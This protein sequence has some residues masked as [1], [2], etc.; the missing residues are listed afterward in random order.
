MVQ[1]SFTGLQEGA[2]RFQP[3]SGFTAGALR[4]VGRAPGA[5]TGLPPAACLWSRCGRAPPQVARFPPAIGIPF[6]KY[7]FFDRPTESALD[8]RF[9]PPAGV[10]FGKNGRF[11]SKRRQRRENKG[12]SM[13]QLPP[14]RQRSPWMTTRSSDFVGDSWLGLALLPIF[15]IFRRRRKPRTNK[16][17][18][19]GHWPRI[20]NQELPLLLGRVAAICLHA[21]PTN[22][23]L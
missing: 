7:A 3:Q 1:A 18:F 17:V 9:F 22:L 20:E 16:R 11:G 12:K 15:L 2:N 13:L 14:G 19:T 6:Y 23:P 8:S 5:G 21:A 4:S 10:L